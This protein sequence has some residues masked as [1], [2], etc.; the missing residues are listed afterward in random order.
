MNVLFVSCLAGMFYF[1]DTYLVWLLPLALLVFYFYRQALRFSSF[2]FMLMIV[3][4][5]YVGLA[6]AVIRLIIEA[7]VLIPMYLMGSA[8]AAV[9]L[10]I[11]LNK[12]VKINARLQ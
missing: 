10:L 11:N 8:V 12:K 7:W 3:L 9:L 1:E 4:Y 5:A 6:Y 2:Y